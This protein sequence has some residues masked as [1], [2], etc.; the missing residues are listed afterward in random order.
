MAYSMLCSVLLTLRACSLSDNY[1]NDDTKRQLREAAPQV[2]FTWD[3]DKEEAEQEA[4]VEAEA[5]DEKEEEDEV[6]M[7]DNEHVGEAMERAS[8]RSRISFYESNA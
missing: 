8:I 5:A 4:E 1:L 6:M 2:K 7:D 3:D